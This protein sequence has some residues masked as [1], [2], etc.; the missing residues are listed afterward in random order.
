MITVLLKI[1]TSDFGLR[2]SPIC[3]WISSLFFLHLYKWISLKYVYTRNGTLILMLKVLRV[4]QDWEF[5]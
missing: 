2:V 1:N 5:S 3:Y 4:Y